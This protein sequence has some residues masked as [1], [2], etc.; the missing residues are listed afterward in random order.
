MINRATISELFYSLAILQQALA[1]T[2]EFDNYSYLWLEDKN[3]F[4]EDFLASGSKMLAEEGGSNNEDA[5][6]EKGDAG[7][8]KIKQFQ[9]QVVY[10]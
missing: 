10:F 2:A 5:D 3:L 1:Y 8:P 6:D 7:P 4:L 9:E